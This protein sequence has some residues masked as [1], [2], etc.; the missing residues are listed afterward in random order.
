MLTEG[1]TAIIMAGGKS[2]RMGTNK[3]LAKYKD[4]RLIDLAIEKAIELTDKILVSTN[5]FLPD[6]DYPQVSDAYTGI[7]PIGGICSC[8]RKSTTNWNLVLACDMP[9]VPV[10]FLKQMTI[11]KNEFQVIL[12]CLENGHLEPLAAFYHRSAIPV[13]AS[14][15]KGGDYKLVNLVNKLNHEQINCS[16]PEYFLNINTINDL[17]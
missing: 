15:I 13:I 9:Q 11:G 1:I 17:K 7:G 5:I 3:A 6:I 14:Q 4:K 12:P 8:M 10:S 2:S 16:H